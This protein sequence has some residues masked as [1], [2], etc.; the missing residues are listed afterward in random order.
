MNEALNM[1]QWENKEKEDARLQREILAM[2]EHE[3]FL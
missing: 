2:F 1:R 3:H